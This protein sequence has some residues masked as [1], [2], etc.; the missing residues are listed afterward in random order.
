MAARSKDVVLR[1]WRKHHGPRRLA[2]T[3]VAVL[4]VAFVA[5][6]GA[7]QRRI[8][9][10]VPALTEMLFA[11]GA[12]PQV[13]GV[14]SFDAFPPEVNKLPRVGALLD[15][16]TERI[17]SLRPTLALIYGSQESLQTQFAR[18]GIR[19]YVYRH[20]GIATI[21]QTM[22]D[23]GDATGTRTQADRLVRE[24]QSKVDAVHGR[25][26]GR[27]QPRVALVIDRQPKTL[28]E[29]Y[30]SGGRG[31]LHEMLEIAGGRNAFGDV[32]R[33]SAQPSQEML[34]AKAPD[35]IIEMRAEGMIAPAAAAGDR[36][37]WSALS[38]LPAV[39]NGRVHILSGQYLVVPGPRFAQAV[40]TLA[41]TLH[42]EAF[43]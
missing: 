2:A 8:V 24:L 10:L 9:S 22:R 12:G 32:D 7:Q 18:A 21:L 6:A 14:G 1:A 3:A 27:P 16:D 20:G 5:A 42:P 34:I 40:E 31:F 19:T 15:P 36:A 11:I 39:R 17:L 4:L 13:V 37:V 23:L 25:V 30:V 38:S 33:E 26:A 29:I 28:R 41:R 35:V 43:R